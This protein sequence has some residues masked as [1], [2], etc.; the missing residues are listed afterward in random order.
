M[1]NIPF[2][3]SIKSGAYFVGIFVLSRELFRKIAGQIKVNIK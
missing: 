2:L 1:V 3:I